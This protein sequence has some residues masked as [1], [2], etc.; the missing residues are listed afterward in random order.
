MFTE[1]LIEYKPDL[2]VISGLHLLE[3]Q[4]EQFRK[5]RLQDLAMHLNTIKR[6]V[7]IHLELAS[8]VKQD[9]MQAV[10]HTIFPLVDSIGL[11]EQELAF[12]TVSVGGPHR[13]D[14]DLR[15][16][17]PEIGRKIFFI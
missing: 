10:V 6:K 15:Q 17:P 14:G 9:M 3:S 2:I 8:M 16:W 1:S 12:L 4:N 7:P 13:T 11:N 5:K